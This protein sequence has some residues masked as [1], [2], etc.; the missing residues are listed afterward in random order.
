MSIASGGLIKWTV[1]LVE[2]TR[3]ATMYNVYIIWVDLFVLANIHSWTALGQYLVYTKV[4]IVL[5]SK[6]KTESGIENKIHRDDSTQ[7]KYVEVESLCFLSI[8][9]SLIK[10]V[11]SEVRHTFY[12]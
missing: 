6:I 12:Y 7:Q 10:I 4:K 8:Y 3:T 11:V 2:D 9:F 1:S 5:E